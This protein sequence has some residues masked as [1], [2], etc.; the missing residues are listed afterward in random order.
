MDK[1]VL[2]EKYLSGSLTEQEQVEFDTLRGKDKAFDQEVVFHEDLRTILAAEED[3]VRGMVEEFES[4]QTS[5]S[6]TSGVWKNLLVAASIFAVFGL[7]V[8]YNL[9]QPISSSDLYENYFD[10]YPNV[11]K[12]MVRGQEVDA[13]SEAFNAYE[14]GRY[15]EAL[16]DF[17]KL[18]EEAD[19]DYYLLYMANTLL[20]LDRPAEAIELLEKLTATDGEWSDK[21]GWYMAMAYLQMDNKEKAKEALSSVVAKGEYNALK[22]EELLLEI[23]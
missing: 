7:A 11:V 22:A 8:F 18:Y 23:E 6:N 17:T 19:S 3:T 16:N 9:S 1:E 13:E 4:E 15:E 10:A 2:I 21:A 14:N 20:V 12:P 5:K